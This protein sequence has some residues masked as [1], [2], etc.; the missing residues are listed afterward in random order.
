MDASETSCWSD[1]R[2]L[3]PAL[4]LAGQWFAAALQQFFVNHGYSTFCLQE[5]SDDTSICL[6]F[7]KEAVDNIKS[8]RC[9]QQHQLLLWLIEHHFTLVAVQ[10]KRGEEIII[11]CQNKLAHSGILCKMFGT[12][13]TVSHYRYIWTPIQVHPIVMNSLQPK[14]ITLAHGDCFIDT[15]INI[16]I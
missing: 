5:Q 13:A 1:H 4:F 14:F 16:F 8:S 9:Q 12:S 10:K 2:W 3:S 15:L 6:F 11:T 7:K